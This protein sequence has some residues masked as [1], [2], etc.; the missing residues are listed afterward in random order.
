MYLLAM[1]L[2]LIIIDIELCL[3]DT[4]SFK[5]FR[6]FDP[7]LVLI[8]VVMHFAAVLAFIQAW[9]VEENMFSNVRIETVKG[10]GFYICYDEGWMIALPFVGIRTTSKRR[11][12]K[13]YESKKV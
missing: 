5:N 13:K 3:L 7:L 9:K 6:E 11:K 12:F 2:I 4:W 8:V 1:P 10:I